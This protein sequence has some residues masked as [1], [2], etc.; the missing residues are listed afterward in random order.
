M[1]HI[2]LK[3]HYGSTQKALQIIFTSTQ[4][5]TIDSKWKSADVFLVGGGG[6]GG[7]VAT[8]N[9]SS[10]GGDPW[11]VVSG[12]GGGHTK[13][14]RNISITSNNI[15]VTIGAGATA[16]I[17]P[18]GNVDERDGNNGSN[19]ICN[20][21]G[22]EIKATGGSGGYATKSGRESGGGGGSGGGAASVNNAQGTVWSGS[23][24]SNGGNGGEAGFENSS[25]TR[26]TVAGGTGQGTTTRVF[27]EDTGTLYAGGGGASKGYGRYS[28]S[29]ETDGKT[30]GNGGGGDGRD[31]KNH[32]A[33][34]YG[35][36]GAGIAGNGYQGVVMVRLY[37]NSDRP[38]NIDWS[39]CT[40]TL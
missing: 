6:S 11:G 2:R 26:Y 7:Y 25:G 27:E 18:S 37:K 35:G 17:S 13:T 15:E 3:R 36:G 12:A 9:Y 22:V 40:I 39:K 1:A 20:I 34:A 4:T 23:G 31:G 8:I 21:N 5:Y 28:Y 16:P 29:S 14:E 24:G 38:T 32:H 10:G 19:T 33:T 30:G